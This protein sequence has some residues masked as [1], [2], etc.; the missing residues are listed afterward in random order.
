MRN[1]ARKA[2]SK[3]MTE[4]SVEGL[5]DMNICPNTAFTIVRGLKMDS[6]DVVGAKCMK[7]ITLKVVSMRMRGGVWKNH[8]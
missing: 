5:P 2:V 3:A 7:G 8:E 6:K 4:N 1:K